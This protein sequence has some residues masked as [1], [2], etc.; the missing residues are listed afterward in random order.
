MP[1]AGSGG[2]VGEWEN[3]TPASI[4]LD[5]GGDNFGV[6][7]VLA[8][9]ARPSDLYTFVCHQ[10]VFKSTDFGINWTKVN[11]GTNGAMIDSG[12]PWGEGIDS[13]RCRD[14]KTPPTLY[15]AGS[16]GGFWKSADGGVNWKKTDLPD[17]G[18]PRPQDDYDVDVDPYDGKHIIVGFHEEGGLVESYDAGE[19]FKPITMDAGM[20]GGASWYGFFVDTGNPA[21]TAKTWLLITQATGGIV[22]TWRTSDGGGKWSRVESNEHGHGQ[23]QIY[24]ANGIVYMAGVYGTKG[25][26]VY[27]SADFGATFTHVG[28]NVALAVVYGTPKNIYGQL[29]GATQ[30]T[31]DQSQDE[32]APAPG[33][34][35]TTWSLNVMKNGPKRAAVTFDGMHYVI[36]GG[37]WNAGIWRY[38]EP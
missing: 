18:K 24:Q 4:N 12:K 27:R 26:G 35:W 13:N 21:T 22:G 19:T 36:V 2:K 37:N 30:G 5:S 9:P 16:Q 29:S 38:V 3:V 1:G 14:P 31:A 15:S 28:N 34:S 33:T 17:D 8:D 7:D 32:R 25:W 10:G 23:S 11:T 20:S 6:Q